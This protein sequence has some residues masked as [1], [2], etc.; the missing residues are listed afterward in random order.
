M[1]PI[2]TAPISL[3]ISLSVLSGWFVSDF[4]VNDVVE[5]VM[6]ESMN[7]VSESVKKIVMIPSTTTPNI[8]TNW[9]SG[10]TSSLSY[11]LPSA[12]VRNDDKDEFV[13][14]GRML[15]DSFGS[16]GKL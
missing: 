13:A 10:S 16:E 3:A 2:I 12:Q 4:R 11:Q 1:K 14:E 8:E 9:Y 7:S 15:G 6:T 5:V